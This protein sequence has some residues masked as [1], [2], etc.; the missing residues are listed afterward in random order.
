MNDHQNA[1]NEFQS[2]LDVE[3]NSADTNYNLAVMYGQAKDKVTA[4]KYLRRALDIKKDHLSAVASLA[5]I[6]SNSNDTDRQKEA[7]LL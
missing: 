3:P 1:M 5:V 6:L 2:A 4:E 7:F